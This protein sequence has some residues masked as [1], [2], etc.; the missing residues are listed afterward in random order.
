M[1][2]ASSTAP[3][4]RSITPS[5]DIS[6]SAS[7]HDDHEGHVEPH[8]LLRHDQRRHHRRQAEDEQHVEDVAADDVADGDVGLARQLA[9]MPTASSGEPVPNA[10]TVSPTTSGVMPTATASRDAPRT[11]SSA[12]EISRT[13]PA[14]NR[15][16]VSSDIST[17]VIVRPAAGAPLAGIRAHNLSPPAHQWPADARDRRAALRLAGATPVAAHPAATLSG[18]HPIRRRPCAHLRI[19]L[20][21]SASRP[22]V[23]PRRRPDVDVREWPVEWEGRPRDPDVDR[24]GPRLVRRPDRQLHRRV[25]PAAESFRRF[26]LEENTL[27]HNLVVGR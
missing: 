22:C 9:W 14:M 1:L 27:P 19:L 5:S 11:S 16:S 25:R 7:R 13:I 4:P 3:S 18:L 23:G 8:E 12:P 24:A 21:S 10:T 26:E 20:A 6:S 2:A 17:S 15:S